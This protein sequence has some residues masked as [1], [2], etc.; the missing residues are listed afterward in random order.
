MKSKLLHRKFKNEGNLGGQSERKAWETLQN[1][2]R[3][4][5]QRN[6][7]QHRGHMEPQSIPPTLPDLFIW[8]IYAELIRGGDS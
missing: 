2:A 3:F 8:R 5:D 1:R 4:E 6:G 7:D